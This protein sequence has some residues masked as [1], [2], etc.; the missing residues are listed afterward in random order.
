LHEWK[1][2]W[3]AH[4]RQL[5]ADTE[6]RRACERALGPAATERMDASD[7]RWPGY[8]GASYCPGGVLMAATVHREVRLWPAP[9]ARDRARQVGRGDSV[10]ARSKAA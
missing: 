8:V 9:A 6:H 4:A 3:L 1:R 5:V 7:L 2:E 10:L